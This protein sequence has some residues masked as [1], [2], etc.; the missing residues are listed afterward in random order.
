VGKRRNTVDPEKDPLTVE[1]VASIL[2]VSRARVYFLCTHGRIQ[3]VRFS[4]SWMISREAL[5]AFVRAPVGRPPK[6]GASETQVVVQE[7]IRR[8]REAKTA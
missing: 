1:D 4:R 5:N 3:A 6:T 7:A 8:F 2:G